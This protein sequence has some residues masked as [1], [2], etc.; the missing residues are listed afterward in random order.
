MPNSMTTLIGNKEKQ[1]NH[2]K[3]PGTLLSKEITKQHA[4]FSSKQTIGKIVWT[5]PEKKVLN[6]L[7][8]I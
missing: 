6:F 4:K 5:R 7:I 3:T 8:D 2:R 1:T